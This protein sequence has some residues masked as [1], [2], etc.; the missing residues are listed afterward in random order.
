MESG[1]TLRNSI[2]PTLMFLGLFSLFFGALYPGV[3]M[4]INK[5]LFTKKAN[6]CLILLDNHIRGSALLGQPFTEPKYFWSRPS[7]TTPLPYSYIHS[8]GSNLSPYQPQ[9]LLRVKQR[10]LDLQKADPTNKELIPID[11]VTTS[12]SGLD[13]HISLASAEYQI[14]RVARARN[15]TERTIIELVQNNIEDRQWGML[16][17][18]RINV[19]TLNMKL[20]ALKQGA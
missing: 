8:Q 19:V 16:G 17:E 13:P 6:G 15:L 20:D 1:T 2:W 4:V 11:L 5:T 7:A 3:V 18:P 12:A 14:A 9:L 10:I